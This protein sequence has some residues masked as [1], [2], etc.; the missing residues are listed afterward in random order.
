MIVLFI[1]F[2]SFMLREGNNQKFS[3]E[4][5]IGL[6]TT[7]L[8][9]EGPIKNEKTSF[10]LS[11]RRTFLDVATLPFKNKNLNDLPAYYFYDLNGKSNHRINKRNRIYLSIYTGEDYSGT[12]YKGSSGDFSKKFECSNGFGWSNLT[13]SARW[14]SVFSKR[15]FSNLTFIY[16]KY[17]FK[18]E[19]T[20]SET[21]DPNGI[22]DVYQS[23]YTSGIDDIGSRWDIEFYAN[24]FHT[25]RTGTNYTYHTF[26]PGFNIRKD[27]QD[28]INNSLDTSYGNKKINIR[29][30]YLYAEDEIKI[31]R[32]TINLGVHFS[33]FK[34]EGV[35]YNLI[36]PRMS[37]SYE[38]TSKLNLKAGYGI[39]NQHL[40]LL[41]NSSIGLP[42]DLWL[43]A[44]RRIKPQHGAYYSTGAYYAFPKG[45]KLSMEGYYREM[46][47]LIEYKEGASFYQYSLSWED[48]GETGKGKAY[49]IE[50]MLQKQEGRLTGW[51]GTTLSRSD[52]K[53]E[54]L[55]NGRTFPFKLKCFKDVH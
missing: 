50:L 4:A 8:L 24:T 51:F 42:T 29:D 36:Q 52:R 1:L 45:L 27:L 2:I 44:T 11:G 15:L 13:T 54:A 14:N 18:T 34:V 33:V 40:H 48:K 5:G 12:K 32:F 7:H 6:L 16:S 30:I 3:G 41:T 38:V 20:K 26:N 53:F 10:I 37:M 22:L 9:L 39:L 55:N 28:S 23:R 17:L 25:L 19:E 49:G 35:N 46:K 43:P 31:K 21:F 47:N